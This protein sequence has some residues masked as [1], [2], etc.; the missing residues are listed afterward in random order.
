MKV[1]PYRFL[2]YC[3]SL[4][5]LLLLVTNCEQE[6]EVETLAQN[7]NDFE[8]R[9]IDNNEI[10]KIENLKEPFE[11]IKGSLVIEKDIF[12][13]TYYQ[14]NDSDK[15]QIAIDKAIE[16]KTDGY[17][18]YSFKVI[19]PNLEKSS[20]ENLIIERYDDSDF[21][22]F[23]YTY[24]TEDNGG[25]S[26]EIVDVKRKEVTADQINLSD[27]SNPLATIMVIENCLV[28]MYV[29]FD[30]GCTYVEIIICWNDGGDGSGEG[31]GDDND[32]DTDNSNDNNNNNNSGD[33]GN[34]TGG[35]GGGSGGSG[36]GGG[37]NHP[38]IGVIDDLDPCPESYI[39]DKDGNCVEQ[40][41]PGDPVPNPEIAPQY[42]KS[43]TKG[44][45]HGCTR[46]GVGCTSPDG[47]TKLH[48]GIDLIND[49]G[50]PIY[51]MYSG[52]IYNTLYDE[53]AGYF[54]QIQS[55]INGETVI[56]KYFHMQE[57]NRIKENNDGTLRFV[58]AGDIIGYQGDSGNLKE[59]IA[60]G[61]VDSHVHIEILSH[62]GSTNWNY[63][64]NFNTV[65]P[66]NYLNTVIN[67]DGTSEEN[68]DCN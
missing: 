9:K 33:S 5:V 51:A 21:K 52:F 30:S 29:D 38:I 34:N 12:N 18:S 58:S 67:N 24:D 48:N 15:I 61:T 50:E 43:G 62:D 7:N 41:C 46:Y 23:I 64:T 26:R 11:K 22:Y 59:A 20:F 55:T 3:T 32:N 56:I 65:D 44:A 16:I 36:E 57:E 40:P 31:D 63:F 1:H 37:K 8:I 28:D 27:F 35:S 2:K 17:E 6:H 14:E 60:D 39:K 54:T 66:R 10:L 49:Y 4:L 42:G 53:D 13:R 47:R 19:N 25:N 68:T 45:L